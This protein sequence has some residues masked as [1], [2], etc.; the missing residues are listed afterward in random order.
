MRPRLA[1]VMSGDEAFR[2]Y[3]SL[4]VPLDFMEDLAGQRNIA[5]DR[6]GYERAMEGQR[7]Q[8]AGG[9]Q[10]RKEAARALALHDDAAI[11]R[12]L[13]AT[14][15]T[16]EGYERLACAA[17]RCVALFDAGGQRS[18]RAAGRR[19]RVRRDRADA[20]LCRSRRAGVRHRA[21]ARRRQRLEAVVE[22]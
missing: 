7:E 9:Q 1:D 5:I 10:L 15:D 20:V 21:H 4:G 22:R 2:L 3:D 14:R 8:G 6:E 12:T 17:C 18:R 11:E 13:E 19:D 16:F